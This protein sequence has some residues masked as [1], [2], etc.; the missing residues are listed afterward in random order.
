MTIVVGILI[1][2]IGCA[3]ATYLKHYPYKPG[4]LNLDLLV[5]LV[6]GLIVGA[7]TGRLFP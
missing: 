3:V 2:C 1:L 6:T 7:I 5:A 4:G